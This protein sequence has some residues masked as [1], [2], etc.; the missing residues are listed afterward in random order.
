MR[1]LS[2]S[3][4]LGRGQAML[5]GAATGGA[6]VGGVSAAT[7]YRSNEQ[8]MWDAVSGAA[9]GLLDG[10]GAVPKASTKMPLV[11][12]TA[13]MVE[14]PRYVS[15]TEA[16][17]ADGTFNRAKEYSPT[18][19]W[20][21]KKSASSLDV[22]TTTGTVN[23]RLVQV[24]QLQDAAEYSKFVKRGRIVLPDNAK[25]TYI[26]E[27]DLVVAVK[28]ALDTPAGQAE[29]LRELGARASAARVLG[30]ETVFDMSVS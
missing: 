3:T 14:T 1:V 8:I 16:A 24:D 12:D 26:P 30:A 28:G 19:R 23:T 21:S 9:G 2:L 20:V 13:N 27:D 10:F 11:G 5:A 15:P 7:G 25:V 18:P 4:Q 17:I 29:L 6:T 22:E